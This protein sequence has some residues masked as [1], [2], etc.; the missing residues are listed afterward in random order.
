M[1]LILRVSGRTWSGVCSF[2]NAYGSSLS[3]WNA[4]QLVDIVQI[5]SCLCLI[6]VLRLRKLESYW[7][8]VYSSQK[9]SKS[10]KRN[11]SLVSC[12]DILQDQKKIEIWSEILHQA[13]PHVLYFHIK[14]FDILPPERS[15]ATCNFLCL[16]IW[17][18]IYHLEL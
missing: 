13:L 12:L 5:L 3:V 1:V 15:I 8:T 11:E 17:N 7:L 6:H 18:H 4:I 9:A 16:W 14:W 10:S 2:D